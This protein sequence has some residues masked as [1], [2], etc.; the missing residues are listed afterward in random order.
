MSA[1]KET[2]LKTSRFSVER[3]THLLPNGHTHSREIVRHPGAVIILPVLADGSVCLIRNYRVSLDQELLELP[4]GTLEAGEPP[5][6]CAVR[7]LKEETGYSCGKMEPLCDFFMSPGILDEHMHA[8]VA[9]ELRPGEPAREEGEL[10]S[11]SILSMAE[12]EAAIRSG[13]VKDAKTIVALLYFSQFWIAN[14]SS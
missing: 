10:I 4:A 5:V 12:T 7:E 2:I 13:E 14:K 1:M 9:T 11:N 6:E 8:F 3:V